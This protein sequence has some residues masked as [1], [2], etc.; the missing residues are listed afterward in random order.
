MSSV[1]NPIW[2]TPTMGGR[3]GVDDCANTFAVKD[4]E[5]SRERRS[6]RF[7]AGMVRP[8]ECGC[9]LEPEIGPASPREVTV[10][11]RH[12]PGFKVKETMFW[13][14]LAAIIFFLLAAVLANIEAAHADGPQ[15]R[16]RKCH[17]SLRNISNV[18]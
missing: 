10:L 2:E 15:A 11:T 17:G 16:P 1:R 6:K 4:S 7:M 14:V 3:L 12:L 5:K 9:Q 13:F 8:G 18:R